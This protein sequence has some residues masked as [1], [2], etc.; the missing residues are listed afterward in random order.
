MLQGIRILSFTHFLQGPSAVQML[1]DL[2]ADVIKIEPPGGAFERSFAGCNAYVNDMSVLFLAANRNQRSLAINLKEQAGKEIIYK[3]IERTDVVIENYRPGVM[4]R[5]G[6]GYERLKEI[7]P[8]LIYASL[9]GYGSDGPYRDK[10]GQDLLVQSLSGMTLLT[11]GSGGRPTPIGMT[12]VDQ[13]AAVLGAFGVLAALFRRERTGKG[14][15]V[16]SNLL[17][18]ALDLQIEPFNYYLNIGKLWDMPDTGISTR[19]HSA[20]YGVYRTKDGWITMSLNPI[21]RMAAAFETDK[22]EGYAAGDEMK[23]RDEIDAIVAELL[24]E[25]TT[26]EWLARFEKHAIWCAPVRTYDEVAADPQVAWNRSIME[27]RHP[28]AGTVR[29]LGHPVK[30]EGYDCGVRRHPPRL[31]EH[32]AELLRETGYSAEEIRKL[33][34]DKVVFGSA[35]NPAE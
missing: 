34:E 35:V 9:T 30:Y 12:A 21:D 8:R 7:N 18:A 23:R 2:G 5:L 26:E 25:K 32:T 19:F 22:F 31:G 14:G 27:V 10:P 15:K 33:L 28:D 11:H 13:H 16:E 1:A 4:D 20:P 24:T 3:L 6:F 17:S 29:L